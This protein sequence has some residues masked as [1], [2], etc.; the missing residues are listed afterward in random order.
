MELV[1]PQDAF[2]LHV[3]TPSVPQHVVGLAF[4]DPST[5]PSGAIELNDVIRSIEGRLRLVPRLR[6]RL[7]VPR[8][9]LSRPA[10]VDATG[11]DI[12]EHIRPVTLPP[13]G[14]RREIIRFLEGVMSERMDRS[15][16]LW[17]LYLIEGTDDGRPV[18]LLKLHHCLADGLG[19]LD[20]AA[21]LFD[22]SPLLPSAPAHRWEPEPV[23]D[24][25][26]LFLL[27]L[28]R[29]LA[30]PLASLSRTVRGFI[31]DPPAAT[32]RGVRLL[33]GLSELALA[34]PAPRSPLNGPVGP[35]RRF[36]S[37]SVDVAI[38]DQV[39]R[40][41]GGS[42]NDIMLTAL[43]SALSLQFRGHRASRQQPSQLRAMVPVSIR[44]RGQQ[45][46]PGNFTAALSVL[47][48]MGDMSSLE[49]LARIRARTR[50]L[51]ASPQPVASRFVMTFVGTWLPAGL[52]AR[53]ARLMYRG[54]WFNCI[55]STMPGPRRP[56]YLAGAKL[57]EGYPVLPLAKDVGLTVG[58]MRWGNEMAIGFTGDRDA[59]LDLDEVAR[60]LRRCL[61]ELA[62]AARAEAIQRAGAREDGRLRAGSPDQAAGNGA[63]DPSG[64]P[65]ATNSD[66]VTGSR[67]PSESPVRIAGSA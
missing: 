34:G 66:S 57:E 67:P 44:T 2:F 9:G 53:L 20:L 41:F 36:A 31:V 26:R 58:A 18:I 38:L 55:V 40:A 60:N 61:D 24:P 23:P 7:A 27:T 42:T 15:R 5:T 37:V 48:P 45:K 63:I 28:G 50:R 51:K 52:H 65:A 33:R 49:R 13:P 35:R 6:Q 11:F 59:P 4:L 64:Q 62:Q 12:R 17:A 16:P 21:A 19:A 39:R 22:P 10:W 46:A 56:M 14:G 8:W 1:D 32:R 54:R 25:V 29:Q 47:L 3:E 43:A 30:S